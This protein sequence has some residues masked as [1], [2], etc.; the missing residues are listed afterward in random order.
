[1]NNTCLLTSPEIRAVSEKCFIKY[2]Q[3]YFWKLKKVPEM[4][5]IVS[6]SFCFVMIIANFIGK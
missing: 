2:G 5:F 1:M 6:F 4:K 3:D